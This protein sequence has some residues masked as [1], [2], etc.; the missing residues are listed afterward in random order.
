MTPATQLTWTLGWR[1]SKCIPISWMSG[2]LAPSCGSHCTLSCCGGGVG[3]ADMTLSDSATLAEA[4]RRLLRRAG[5]LAP[6]P[7][8]STGATISNCMPGLNTS[9]TMLLLLFLLLLLLLLRTA[10]ERGI[11]DADLLGVAVNSL[12]KKLTLALAAR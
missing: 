6:H 5:R 8:P 9:T 12:S 11:L 3:G 2:P 4:K 10:D 7:A 1:A